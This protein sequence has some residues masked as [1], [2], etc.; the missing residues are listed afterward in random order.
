V[1]TTSELLLKLR[2]KSPY[3]TSEFNLAE[4]EYVFSTESIDSAESNVYLNSENNSLS[5]ITD[6][7]GR[8]LLLYK[9]LNNKM[10]GSS[11]IS[12][13]KQGTYS[14]TKF[15]HSSP[16]IIKVLVFLSKLITFLPH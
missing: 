4:I 5:T 6:F 11:S 2:F 7:A 15:I 1:L 9:S 10:Q 16:S 12:A 14:I 3:A 13:S 8:I